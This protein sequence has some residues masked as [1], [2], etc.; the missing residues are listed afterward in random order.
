MKPIVFDPS[1]DVEPIPFEQ[2]HLN[3]AKE[4]KKKGL[5]W[6]PHVGCFVWDFSGLIA[7]RSPFPLQIYFI[8][9]LPRFVDLLGSIDNVATKLVW[10]PTWHQARIIAF[11]HGI[12]NKTIA[13]IWQQENDVGAGQD[14][15]CLYRLISEAL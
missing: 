8:L 4:M 1:Q 11:R 7:V 6:Q 10:L 12:E 15:L 5:V 14:L 2:P 9:S 3:L 13:S